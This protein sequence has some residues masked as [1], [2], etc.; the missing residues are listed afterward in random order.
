MKLLI[1]SMM[2]APDNFRINEI[3]EMLAAEGHEVRVVT[4]LPD[5]S[6]S[7]IPK[8]FRFFRRRHEKKGNVEVVRL[9]IIARRHGVFFRALNYASFMISGWFYAHFCRR[10][11]VDAILVYETSPILQ[12]GP[13]VVFKKR[14]KVPLMMYCCDLWP[15]AMKVWGVGEGNP[16]FRMIKRKSRKLYQACDV[17][18]VSSEPFIPYIAELCDMPVERLPYL[19]QHCTDDFA[20][21]ASKYDEDGCTDFL[22]AGNIGTAQRVDVILQA[23][24]QMKTDKPFLVH[25]VGDGSEKEACEQLAEQLHI[26]DKVVFHGRHPLSEMPTFY[27][28]AD[29][30]LLTL[31]GGNGVGYTLPAKAQ[32]YLC[33][34]KPIAAAIDGAGQELIR[35]ADCGEAVEAENVSGLAAMMDRMAEQPSAYREKGANGRRYYEQHFTPQRFMQ[36]LMTLLEELKDG[37][38]SGS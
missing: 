15:E 22:F 35:Q 11:Q 25:L 23:V 5:Y 26:T 17:V 14:L 9:P 2:Y 16:L 32:G 33:A 27:R 28:K 3:V 20:D 30:F 34:G 24:A 36:K 18:A 38:H 21:I 7:R 6:T 1:V 10:P 13:A 31:C 29:V 19:P 12:T 37:A 4:G 8:E